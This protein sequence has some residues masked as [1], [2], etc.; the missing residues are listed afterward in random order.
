MYLSQPSEGST[1]WALGGGLRA[2]QMRMPSIS[3]GELTQTLMP[4]A[5]AKS[6][7]FQDRVEPAAYG[8]T[9]IFCT[10]RAQ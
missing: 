7:Y 6:Y 5:T 2:F 9:P 10:M 3:S 8:P 4:Q 1:S